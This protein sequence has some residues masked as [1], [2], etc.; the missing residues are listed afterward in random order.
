MTATFLLPFAMGACQAVGGNIVRDAFGVV[1]M[2][3][4]TL[5]IA[6]QIQETGNGRTGDNLCLLS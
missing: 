6:V 2:A 1:A 4:M 5:L 3:A